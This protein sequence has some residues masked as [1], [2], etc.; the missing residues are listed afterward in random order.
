MENRITTILGMKGSGKTTLVK[1]LTKNR[2]RILFLDPNHEYRQG[3]IFRSFQDLLGWH[4][5]GE[6]R[7]QRYICRFESDAE[8][9]Q[10]LE[11]VW[12]LRGW[13]FVAEEVDLICSPTSIDETFSRI[14][15]HGRHRSIDVFAVSRRPAEISKLLTSQSDEIVTFMHEEDLDL[16]YLKRRGFDRD[17]VVALKQYEYISNTDHEV[18]T[19][20][21]NQ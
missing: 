6:D 13:A 19:T 20:N 17:Q 1:A 21:P 5:L 2:R 15:R 10:A 16:D 7:E 4:K 14:I 8:I 12:A 9:E 3:L 11:F 18:R